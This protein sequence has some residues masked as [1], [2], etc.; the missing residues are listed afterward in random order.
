MAS[1]ATPSTSGIHTKVSGDTNQPSEDDS[2]SILIET[3]G[4]SDSVI[5]K[6]DSGTDSDGGC[7][8]GTQKPTVTHNTVNSG[9]QFSSAPQP[10]F[11]AKKMMSITKKSRRRQK[12][13]VQRKR[14]KTLL[15]RKRG[16]TASR[17]D[18]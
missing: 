9:R 8:D 17:K 2:D 1:E 18:R 11:L 7:M 3:D 14:V 12:Y 4:D 10:T 16:S 5:V 6:T 13:R 15:L